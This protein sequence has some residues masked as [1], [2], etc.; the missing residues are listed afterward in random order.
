MTEHTAYFCSTV[1]QH[2]SPEDAAVI[3]KK[4]PHKKEKL[5]TAAMTSKREAIRSKSGFIFRAAFARG[6]LDP[7]L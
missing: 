3:G 4:Y 6:R 1:A 2:P 7:I 5:T